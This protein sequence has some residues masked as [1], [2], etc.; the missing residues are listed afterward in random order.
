MKGPN[1]PSSVYS[2]NHLE[3]LGNNW[4]INSYLTEN[5]ELIKD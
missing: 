2:A 1:K 3:T 5:R 4:L